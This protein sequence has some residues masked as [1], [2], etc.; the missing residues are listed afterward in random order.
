MM[1]GSRQ[2]IGLAVLA[3]CVL[4]AGVLRV[5]ADRPPEGGF[6]F[7]WPA[8]EYA[9]F[10]WMALCT[11]LIVGAA[12]GV[13]GTLLQSMLRNPLASPF[14]LGVSS[15]AGLG[16]MLALYI[17]HINGHIP[18]TLF[19]TVPAVLGAFGVLAV[20]FALGRRERGLDPVTVILVGV[21]L[22]T[23]CGAGMMLLQSLVPTG[24]RGEFLRWLM[25]RI[26]EAPSMATLSVCAALTVVGTLIAMRMGRA[27]DVSVLPDDECHAAGV[28]LRRLRLW[29]F[30]VAGVL[31][32][33]AVALAGPIGFV[34]LIAPHAARIVL[35][36][37]HTARLLGAVLI[38]AML[39]VGGDVIRQS[40]DLGH[41]RLPI[42]IFTALLGGPAFIWL[43]LSG[44][45][46]S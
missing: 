18:G 30:I 14:I 15:G 31:A 11:G 39:V 8:E 20:V 23:M 6:G 40:I 28:S 4:C 16:V 2:W 21:V 22:S 12:L 27:M 10:R 38:G 43:L 41:G 7:A 45:A 35:G 33:A 46:T 24:L 5:L 19:E 1:R 9:L 36:P 44:R 3:L 25:G 29:Q 13:S 32:A 34:G 37:E 42:G 26:P 17:A